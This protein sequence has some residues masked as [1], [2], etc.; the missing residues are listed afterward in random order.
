MARATKPRACPFCGSQMK[1]RPNIMYHVEESNCII[2]DVG[3]P[4][5]FVDRWNRRTMEPDVLE[6]LQ[7][8]VE[9]MESVDPDSFTLR[10]TRELIERYG[11]G[12]DQHLS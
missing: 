7:D 11:G 1:V 12:G 2:G 4:P 6:Q 10:N 8:T 9:F 5:E 3:F